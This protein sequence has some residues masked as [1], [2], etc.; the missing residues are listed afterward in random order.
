[1][2][3]PARDFTNQYISTSYQDVLQKYNP[4]DIFYVLDGLGNVVFSLPSSS[5]GQVLIT[6]DITS[7]MTVASASY[8]TTYSYVQIVSSSFASE[9][10]SASYA[11]SASHAE[12]SDN[13][14]FALASYYSTVSDT[15][16]YLRPGANIHLSQSYI[17]STTGSTEPAY[18]PAALWWDDNAK[19]YAIYTDHPGLALQIGQEEWVRAYA[20]EYIPNGSA[21]Y[22]SSSLNDLPIVKLALADGVIDS[23]KASVIG[24]STEAIASGSI[25]VITSAGQVHDLNTSDYYSGQIVYLSNTISGSLTGSSPVDPYQNVVVGYVIKSDST[26]GIIQVN[27]SNLGTTEFSFVGVTTMPT[28]TE[29]GGGSFTVSTCSVNLCVTSDGTGHVHNFQVPSA[30]FTVTSSFLDVQYLVVR[31]NGGSPQYD[32]YTNLS[33]VDEIQTTAVAT[34]TIGTNG[35]LS[36]VNWDAPGTLLA[37]KHEKR[38]IDIYGAQR[39]SGLDLQYSAS[40]ITITGGTG[41]IGVKRITFTTAS[42]VNANQFVLLG[43]SSS[44]WSGS[45]INGWINDRYDNGTNL[46]SLGNNRYVVNYVYRGIGSQNRCQ[47]ILSNQF[48]QYADAVASVV[49]QTPSELKDIAILVGRIITQQGHSTPL[50]VESAFTTILSVAGITDHNSLLNIQGG[51]VGEYYHLSSASYAR[52]QSNTSSYAITASYALNGGGGGT[53]LVTGSTYPITASWAI[54]ASWAPGGGSSDTASYSFTSSFAQFALTA[55]YINVI[56]SG[57]TE[58]SSYAITSSY[59]NVAQRVVDS[60][61]SIPPYDYSNIIYNG[62]QSQFGSCTYRI[63]GISGSIVAVVTGIYSGNLFIG[64]SKSLS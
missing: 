58:S 4:T 53:F 44:V 52:V 43:H 20:G 40:H 45:F 23:R 9:S 50:L 28:I 24:L 6:S 54:S 59:S 14:D 57:S 12:T 55:S 3:F 48:N 42:T 10:I 17:F 7:S 49:P 39:A 30:S 51:Q 64:V 37:N 41:Y 61:L 16:S 5:V 22:I 35:S 33:N 8:A 15:A 26:S 13:A 29:T 63:G 32:I 19:T 36:Y 11:F 25:G 34:F 60:G 31:Y 21:V 1:M 47:V 62:P 2:Q 46:V 18:R 56:P 38:I 27:I